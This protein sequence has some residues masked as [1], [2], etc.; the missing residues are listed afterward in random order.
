MLHLFDSNAKQFLNITD[1]TINP[2]AKWVCGT[3]FTATLSWAGW[4]TSE[5]MTAKQAAI[6]VRDA[7]SRLDNRFI[8][9]DQRLER[10]EV[11]LMQQG[12]RNNDARNQ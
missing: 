7:I 11:L 6:D 10:I 8:V 2:I 9:I 5:L 12:V 1:I 3:L 4:T